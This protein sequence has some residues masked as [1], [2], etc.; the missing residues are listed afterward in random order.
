MNIILVK[1]IILDLWWFGKEGKL[2]RIDIESQN[3][4]PTSLNQINV[5]NKHFNEVSKEKGEFYIF[6]SV[7]NSI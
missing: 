2:N 6:V 7:K 3:F 4:K 1:K 5:F